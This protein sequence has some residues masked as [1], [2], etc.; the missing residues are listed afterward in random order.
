MA[1]TRPNNW[2]GVAGW[3]L[4]LL[5]VLAAVPAGP[6]KPLVLQVVPL[7]IRPTTFTIAEVR[8]E[9]PDRTAVTWLLPAP[10]KPG[11]LPGAPVAVDLQGG[12][13]EALQQFFRKS[14][15]HNA[16]QR[17][18]IIRIKECRVTETAASGGQI[19]GPITLQ[20]AFEWQRPEGPPLLLTEYRGGARYGRLPSDHSLVEPT[21]RRSLTDALRYLNGWMNAATAHDVRLATG[22]HPTFHN[23]LRRTEPDTLFYD[24]A[25]PLR[26]S[27]FTGQPRSGDYAA[28]VFPGFAYR[29]QPRVQNG[30][31]ELDLTLQVFVV[32]SSS[33]VGPGQQT[34]SH[35]NHE[36]RHFDLVKLVA[37]RFRRK[38][39]ADS[40][41]VEDYNSILQLQYLKSFTEMN[42]LQDQYDAETHHGTDAAGQQRWNQRIDAELG[43]YGVTSARP[44]D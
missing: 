37:E 33:W 15:P 24:P 38:A 28:A 6:P 22:V 31:V 42:R 8:D 14:L 12:G 13:T 21:L 32:R 27:D 25:R 20:L 9:R 34:A 18:I 41:T 30:V 11:A 10:A 1:D 16:A 44:A 7:D 19:E 36:Q 5:V 3:L 35:L 39:T 2:P 40:L 29:G 26:W 4:L 23:D 17:P 43:R